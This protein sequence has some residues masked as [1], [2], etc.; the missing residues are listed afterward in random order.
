MVEFSN[1]KMNP[2]PVMI[3]ERIVNPTRNACDNTLE[4]LN[5][6]LLMKVADL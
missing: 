3:S 5:Q 1:T 6:C 2:A 4:T